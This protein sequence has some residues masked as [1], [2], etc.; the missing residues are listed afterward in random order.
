MHMEMLEECGVGKRARLTYMGGILW[1]LTRIVGPFVIEHFG[2][3]SMR[4]SS[5]LNLNKRVLDYNQKY[6]QLDK[7]FLYG[8]PIRCSPKNREQVVIV[9]CLED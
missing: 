6:S 2:P 3:L 9:G 1:T 7:N 8:L 5:V 4:D